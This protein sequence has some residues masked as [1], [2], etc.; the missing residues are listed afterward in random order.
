MFPLFA[1]DVHSLDHPEVVRFRAI[2]EGMARAYGGRLLSFAIDHGVVAFS[3]DSEEMARDLLEDLAQRAGAPVEVIPDKEAFV[4][5]GRKM[6][7][8]RR[9]ESAS[10]GKED[11][12]LVSAPGAS[13][14]SNPEE[15]VKALLLDVLRLTDEARFQE[16]MPV[17]LQA[18][19]LAEE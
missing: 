13:V 16:A 15:Q 3:V 6:L 7:D 19:A 18:C 4:A 2:L 8:E 11:N 9:K 1:S 12:H 5:A 10:P 17:A 14:R